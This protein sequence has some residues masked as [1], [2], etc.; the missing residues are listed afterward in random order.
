MTRGQLAGEGETGH[1]AAQVPSCLDRA[2]PGMAGCGLRINEALAVSEDDL[3]FASHLLHV[4]RQI[5]HL[6][7]YGRMQKHSHER[8]REII[9]KRMFRPRALSGG[10]SGE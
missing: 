10:G 6:G 2:G 9:D 5:K 4:R 1:G 7:I 3:D 8:A